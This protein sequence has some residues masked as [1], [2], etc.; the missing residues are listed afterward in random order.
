M[1]FD[2]RY[3][4]LDPA[5]EQR[6]RLAANAL[7]AHRVQ[8]RAAQW[9]GT[10]CD[11]VAADPGDEYGR[12]VLEIARRRGTPALEVGSAARTAE[13]GTTVARLT[14]ALYEL[15]RGSD[16]NAPSTSVPGFSAAAGTS[17]LVRLAGD[18]ALAG[19]DVEARLR[20]I[21]VWLLPES[22]RVL[23]ATVSDQ[24]RARERLAADADWTFTPLAAGSQRG[25]PPGE[26]STSLD[27]FLLHAAWQ[28]RAQLPEFPSR[29]IALRDWLDLGA[30][31]ALV[32]PLAVVQAL[33]RG[34]ATVTQI[35]RR[36]GIAEKDAGACLWAFK[37]AGLLHDRAAVAPP[38]ETAKPRIGGLFTR[39]AAHFGLL[40][41]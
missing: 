11:I 4:G 21:V 30:A 40:R 10:R 12:R 34:P 14:R 31:A 23:S 41:A 19:R 1:P 37:A 7:A 18:E 28:A 33:Q 24:L 29:D 25:E 9:D 17:G 3:A 20:N 35:A 13:Q 8:A 2:L 15:L 16:G 5:M 39:L 32:E 27:A 26:V 36:T 22:G 38:P 6:V